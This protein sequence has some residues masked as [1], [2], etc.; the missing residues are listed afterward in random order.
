MTKKKKKKKTQLA[1]LIW[2]FEGE[3]LV[4]SPNQETESELS[5]KE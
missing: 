4:M 3:H 1:D 2:G 5:F